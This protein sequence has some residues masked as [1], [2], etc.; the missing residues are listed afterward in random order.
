MLKSRRTWFES[1][2][3]CSIMCNGVASLLLL[4][5]AF[6][7][8]SPGGVDSLLLDPPA[9]GNIFSGVVSLLLLVPTADDKVL[10]G[11]LSSIPSALSCLDLLTGLIS[12]SPAAVPFSPALVDPKAALSFVNIVSG[13]S[14]T[15][16]LSFTSSSSCV[17]LLCASSSFS[18]SS[19]YRTLLSSFWVLFS[20]DSVS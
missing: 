5:S 14:D 9:V 8:I 15:F 12:C 7:N 4:S 19:S 13:L 16:I 20:D 17:L 3:V 2:A 1:D 18:K 10:A 11:G 6:L